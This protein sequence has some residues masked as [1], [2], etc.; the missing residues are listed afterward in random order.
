MEP[1]VKYRPGALGLIGLIF[2]PIGLLFLILGIVI[3]SEAI[4]GSSAVFKGVFCGV[5]GL[6]AVLGGIFLGISVMQHSKIKKL[7]AAGNYIMADFT[8]ANLN[9][10]IE[11][12]GMNP[13]RA[14]FQFVD[15]LGGVHVFRSRNI[16]TDPTPALTGRQ[17]RVYV[18]PQNYDNYYAD[19]DSILTV[20]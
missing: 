6:F 8:G 10:S 19:I 17:V 20:H 2:L 4:S 18:D 9:M 7:V 16:M 5:G 3:P 12:N 15:P 13:Y 14:E 11:I 1:N